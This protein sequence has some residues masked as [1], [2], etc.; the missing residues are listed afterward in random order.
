MMKHQEIKQVLNDLTKDI[1]SIADKKA[2]TIIKVLVNLVE[3]LVEENAV[4]R[5]ENQLLRDD[6]NRLKGE[7]GKPDIRGQSKGGGGN[8]NHSSEGDRSKRGKGNNKNKGKDKK[9]VHIDKRITIALDKTKL[10]DDAQFK[11]FE[12]RII[13]DLKI[14]T[15]NIEF[16]LEAYYSPSL[17]KT[18]IAPIPDEYKGSEFGPGVKAL[19]ITLYRDAGMTELAIERFLKTCGLQIS[20]G[21]I[22]SMLTEGN[23]IFHQEKEDIVD[24]GSKA[25][26]YQQMDDTGS[27]VNGKNHYTHVLCNDFFTAYFTR[28][29]KDRLTLL[30][31]LCR[32]QLKFMFNEEAYELMV[33][34]GL[35]TKWLDQIKPI[36]HA[37]PLTRE[38][39]DSLLETL[40]PN[41][42]K[43]STNRRVVLESAA[44]AYYQ[45][46]EY[47]IFQ[48][49]SQ[50]G[51][52][53]KD[54][55][56]TIVQTAR[57]LKVN[58]YQYIYDRVTKKFEMPSLAELILLK[59]QAPSAA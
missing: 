6:I 29:K 3:M 49:V 26:L 15:D 14:I 32:D 36:L 21:K 42:N 50:N 24:A 35:A 7:Q 4:L 8:T 2:V 16:K 59:A 27:R 33:E 46:S 55:F 56:A 40:F 57:K 48:T 25:G 58:V 53:S 22:A 23:D 11:G 20:H 41:P 10:P 43:H 44:L 34:F 47:F 54:T 30:E 31:L 9:N 12:T 37:K 28:R 51:T 13:Q 45:H 38:E 5:E 19:V 18:F 17:K 52:K 39:I 1:D